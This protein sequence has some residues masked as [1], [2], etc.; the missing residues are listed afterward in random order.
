MEDRKDIEK[1]KKGLRKNMDTESERKE[2]GYKEDTE[3]IQKGLE[4]IQKGYGKGTER[5]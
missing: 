1:I 5:I 3:R 2:K 4:T